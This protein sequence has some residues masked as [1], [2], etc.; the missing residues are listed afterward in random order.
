MRITEPWI[1]YHEK[2]VTKCKIDGVI[3]EYGACSE[4]GRHSDKDPK[5]IYPKREYLGYG[6]IYS[7]GGVIQ[8]GS[9]RIYHFFK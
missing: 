1:N 6:T 4:L 5:D 9:E 3:Q 7:I 8:S 2:K